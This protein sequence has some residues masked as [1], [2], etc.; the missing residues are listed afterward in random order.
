MRRDYI[1]QKGFQIVEMWECELWSHDET[2]A[3]VK[4]HHRENCPCKRPLSEEQ[5]LQGFIDGKLFGCV[6]CHIEVPEHLRRYFSNFPPIF[7]NT[8][9]SREGI[10]TLKREHAKREKLLAQTKRIVV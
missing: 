2:D 6:L 4:N 10:G 8:V 3:Y 5:L 1:R 9:A 7:K